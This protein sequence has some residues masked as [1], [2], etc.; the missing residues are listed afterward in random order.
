MAIEAEVGDLVAL[1]SKGLTRIYVTLRDPEG[2]LTFSQRILEPE[3]FALVIRREAD[4]I[5]VYSSKGKRGWTR[6]TLFNVVAR[7]RLIGGVG[8]TP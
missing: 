8:S 6:A 3:E 2:T 5:Y 7:Y 1:D 4:E